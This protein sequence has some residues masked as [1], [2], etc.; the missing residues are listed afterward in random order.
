MVAKFCFQ[1]G[2]QLK[3]PDSPIVCSKCNTVNT[4]RSSYCKTC[5][6]KLVGT[7]ATKI[8]PRCGNT[9]HANGNICEKCGYAFSSASAAYPRNGSHAAKAA[10]ASLTQQ[11]AAQRQ[12][13]NAKN[14][15]RGN[16]KGRA[17]GFFALILAL[18]AAY[19]L[20]MPPFIALQGFGLGFLRADGATFTGWNYIKNIINNFSGLFASQTVLDW[21]IFGVFALTLL[22]ALVEFICGLVQL[23]KGRQAKKAKGLLLFVAIITLL[24]AAFVNLALNGDSL[25]ASSSGFF[26]D[27]FRWFGTFKA[28]RMGSLSVSWIFN[29][30][31]AY[32]FVA[33]FFSVFFKISKKE[34]KVL[35][36][37][38]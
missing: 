31:A 26:A 19:F 8:C 13:G 16:G 37:E 24:A 32:M 21:L 25:A 23:I 34:Q 28:S 4:G 7:S 29:L 18:A 15:Y 14:T 1:C 12:R 3:S 27:I 30:C 38:R 10:S 36:L 11:A 35:H 2:T 33:F 9:V 17:A 20:I 6:N 22:T 5:G